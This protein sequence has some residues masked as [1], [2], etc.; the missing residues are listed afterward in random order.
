MKLFIDIGN[1]RLKWV[2]GAPGN[3]SRRGD[4]VL[5]APDWVRTLDEAFRACPAPAGVWVASVS[6]AETNATVARACENAWQCKARFLASTAACAGVR[7]GYDNPTALGVDRWAAMVAAYRQM[8]GAVCVVSCGTAVTLDL[9]DRAGQHRGGV[10][11]PGLALM[12]RALLSGT[13]GIGSGEGRGTTVTATTT[14]DAV[15]GG[16][17]QGLAGAI[18]HIVAAQRRVVGT[19]APV[20]VTGGD[21]A[22]LLPLLHLDHMSHAPDLVFNGLAILAEMQC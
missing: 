3:W 22:A 15:A 12:R 8:A 7:N 20:V 9:V 18:E 2:L 4:I 6:D 13:A 21:A 14:G 16:T 17:L 5:G 19:S 1:T 11:V 10:I